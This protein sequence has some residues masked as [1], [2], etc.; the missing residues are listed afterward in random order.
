MVEFDEWFDMEIF[1][2]PKFYI[3]LI[4]SLIVTIGVISTWSGKVP[5]VKGYYFMAI[6]G[7]LVADW[8]MTIRDA[9]KN[10]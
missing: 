5:G 6:V 10:G 4:I 8:F 2:N 7:S 9:E 3:S 1:G